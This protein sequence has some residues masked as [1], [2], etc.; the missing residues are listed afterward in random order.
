MGP[1]AHCRLAVCLHKESLYAMSNDFCGCRLLRRRRVTTGH[2]GDDGRSYF[3][4]F[5]LRQ[6]RIGTRGHLTR[7][8][9][10]H[11]GQSTNPSSLPAVS[12]RRDLSL[13]A[14][15]SSNEMLMERSSYQ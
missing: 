13:L 15:F 1:M 10:C 3:S 7:S 12:R 9:R 14:I 8:R 4:G 2:N 11:V 5:L 6:Q